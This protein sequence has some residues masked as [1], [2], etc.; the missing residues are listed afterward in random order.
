MRV[1]YA[2]SPQNVA[3]L[4]SGRL[5]PH[6]SATGLRQSFLSDDYKTST[7]FATQETDRLKHG[8]ND[9]ANTTEQKQMDNEPDQEEVDMYYNEA[10]ALACLIVAAVFTT[11]VVFA[12]IFGG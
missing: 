1:F 9:L 11:V 6:L 8:T 7:E 5:C 4:S 12:S 3:S 2:V 10:A